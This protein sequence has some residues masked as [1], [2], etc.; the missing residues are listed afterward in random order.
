MSLEAETAPKM[1]LAEL[2]QEYDLTGE[3]LGEYVFSQKSQ[4]KDDFLFFFLR[5]GGAGRVE[6]IIRKSDGK[7]F[8]MKVMVYDDWNDAEVEML[9]SLVCSHIF[10]SIFLYF[11]VHCTN[12]F[13]T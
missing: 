7:P 1:S 12:F 11:V 8:A 5:R 2:K 3:I 10:F 13:S 9:Q 6:K 4:H